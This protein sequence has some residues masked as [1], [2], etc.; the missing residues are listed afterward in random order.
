MQDVAAPELAPD[1]ETT[2]QVTAIETT[3]G[4]VGVLG[5]TA[6][7]L[8][9]TGHALVTTR[10]VIKYKTLQTSHCITMWGSAL[11]MMRAQSEAGHT[12]LPH[13]TLAQGTATHA[14]DSCATKQERIT[15]AQSE[16]G[17]KVLPHTT[18]VQ[19]IA[20]H[21]ADSCVT[22]QQRTTGEAGVRL[23]VPDV[24]VK[25]FRNPEVAATAIDR[26][27]EVA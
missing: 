25:H 19:G 3:V 16:A 13:T 15:R 27:A 8:T 20:A 14:A 22:K 11:L 12:A 6:M 10:G 1:A 24:P 7:L 4:Q 23:Q 21:V 5:D 26:T 2:T 18:P 17:R 9:I